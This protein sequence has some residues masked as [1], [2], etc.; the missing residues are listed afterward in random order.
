MQELI[1][2]LGIDWKLL[3]AQVVNFLILLFV[4]K[5][6]LYRPVLEL[7][8]KRRKDI[9]ESAKNVERIAGELAGVE[10]RRTAEF[11]KAKREADA[12]VQEAR[13][14]AK[15]RGEALI[16]EAE[17]KVEKLVVEAKRRIEEERVKMID[18]AGHDVKELV[19][20]V[21]EKVLRE[22]LPESAHEKFVKEAIS[23]LKRQ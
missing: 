5:K 17:V 8:A 11:E 1:H 21:A 9:E 4:L 13:Q 2:K 15:E 23:T 16:H 12:I 18:E 7:L 20:L 22:R 14:A 19:F 10:Q 3:L 6:F